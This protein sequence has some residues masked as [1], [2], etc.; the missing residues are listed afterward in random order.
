M[1]DTI[2][3]IK[4]ATARENITY[5]FQPNDQLDAIK[6]AI[7]KKCSIKQKLSTSSS[8]IADSPIHMQHHIG[9]LP[10]PP[11]EEK[12]VI[13]ILP[14]SAPKQ[15]SL[16]S[17]EIR[18]KIQYL[19]DE[20]HR[21]FQLIKQMMVQE[22]SKRRQAKAQ[23]LENKQRTLPQSMPTTPVTP[24]APAQQQQS[25]KRSRWGAPAID[26]TSPFYNSSNS[27]FY[28]RPTPSSRNNS[29]YPYSNQ[30]RSRQHHSQQYYLP[31][32]PPYS[33]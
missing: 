14:S 8:S 31:S 12:K 25:K 33:R 3:E 19:K 18:E 17:Q 21:L 32:R 4:Q 1:K 23:E 27:Y 15:P 26:T 9:G 6:D 5:H 22:E 16:S 29:G 7:V 13:S 20:K 11:V 24:T 2:F 30:Q 10:S 28:S